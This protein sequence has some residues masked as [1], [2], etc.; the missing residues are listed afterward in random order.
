MILTNS[1]IVE[2]QPYFLICR[3]LIVLCLSASLWGCTMTFQIEN[4]VPIPL[5]EPLPISVY[6]YY[7]TS[8]REYEYREERSDGSVLVNQIGEAQQ[9]VFDQLFVSLFRSAE[10][11]ADLNIEPLDKNSADIIVTMAVEDYVIT[12]PR[13]S[14]LDFYEVT[15]RYRLTL[16]NLQG[17]F[18]SAWSA[19]GYGRH[20]KTNFMPLAATAEAT[21]EAIRDVATLIAIELGNTPEIKSII[22]RKY[23]IKTEC[24]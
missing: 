17:E 5:I 11:I 20:R 3:M 12:K 16:Y 23:K 21:E 1:S 15:I 24:G 7:P 10:R 19:N 18:I 13:D 14:G 22:C 8:F 6:I 2:N 9:D 4:T